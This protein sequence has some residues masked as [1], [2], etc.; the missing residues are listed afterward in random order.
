MVPNRKEEVS[1]SVAAKLLGYSPSYIRMLFNDNK[2]EGTR[3]GPRR[4][5][6]KRKSIAEWI[7]KYNS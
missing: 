4:I 5:M 3:Y 6:I 2:L 1:V 7:N